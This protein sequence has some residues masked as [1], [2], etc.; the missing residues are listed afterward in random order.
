[1]NVKFTNGNTTVEVETD[2]I[3][4]KGDMVVTNGQILGR[5]DDAS[6]YYEDGKETRVIVFLF[7][8]NS[9]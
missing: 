8:P 1:M 2:N 3:P 7:M 9:N 6:Y 5:V 4:V